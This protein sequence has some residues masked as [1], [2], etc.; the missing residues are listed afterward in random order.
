MKCRSDNPVF[1]HSGSDII[2]KRDIGGSDFV[3]SQAP[4]F[5]AIVT[6]VTLVTLKDKSMYVKNN[7]NYRTSI[8]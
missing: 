4:D 5:T 2:A 7:V 6:L 8:K 1:T 3:T